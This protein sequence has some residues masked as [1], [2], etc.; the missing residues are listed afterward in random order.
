[1]AALASAA[2]CGGLTT[3]NCNDTVTSDYTLTTSLNCSGVPAKNDHAL[4]VASNV[5]LTCEAG[6]VTGGSVTGVNGIQIVGRTNV[7]VDGCSATG[8]DI[9]V[10]VHDSTD[11]DLANVLANNNQKYG[12]EVSDDPDGVL[13]SQAV[14]VITSQARGNGDE[15][16]HVSGDAAATGAPGHR[17]FNNLVT[18]NACEGIYVLNINGVSG[19]RGVYVQNNILYGNGANCPG[20]AAA[21]IFIDTSS[22]NRVRF[23]NLTHDDL[24]LRLSS[25]NSLT[26]NVINFGRVKLEQDSDGNELQRVC[27]QGNL[28]DPADSFVLDDSHDNDCTDCVSIK[29]DSN[30]V[31]MTNGV[32][33]N[34]VF[35]RFRTTTNGSPVVSDPDGGVTF[36][37]PGG[38]PLDCQM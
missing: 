13:D 23:N 15:G 34:N 2:N 6:G 24:Q 4:V 7:R 32:G 12:I 36:V 22:R 14:T 3:C 35:R 25:D 11:V 9:G 21:G 30:D 5:V 29:P 31:A 17:I 18:G 19:S 26:D 38:A 37:N 16:I 33:G 28:T 20:G 8:F 27:V 1:M 10:R